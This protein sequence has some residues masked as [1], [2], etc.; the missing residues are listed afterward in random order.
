MLR[1]LALGH[2]TRRGPPKD[3]IHTPSR[4]TF[5]WGNILRTFAGIMYPNRSALRRLANEEGVST[6]YAQRALAKPPAAFLDLALRVVQKG[7]RSC[8]VVAKQ[9]S[10]FAWAS[11]HISRPRT[12]PFP[13]RARPD[14]I[15]GHTG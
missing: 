9:G 5:G 12:A 8:R 6:I 10:T 1:R 13:W 2:T 3:V 7:A 15:V 14:D 11:Y 4:I